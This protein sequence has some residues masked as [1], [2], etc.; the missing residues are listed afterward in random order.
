MARHSAARCRG[1]TNTGHPQ[2]KIVTL[3]VKQRRLRSARTRT[4]RPERT[5]GA[6]SRGPPDGYR[7]HRSHAGAFLP[8]RVLSSMVAF[9]CSNPE[10]EQ[11]SWRPPKH[12]AEPWS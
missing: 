6:E 12:R 2:G 7:N 4:N 8:W 3:S 1:K 5:I 10:V 9:E 11:T